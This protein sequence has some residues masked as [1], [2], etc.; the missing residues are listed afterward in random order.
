FNSCNELKK[1]FHEAAVNRDS[2][3]WWHLKK[4]IENTS[5]VNSTAQVWG[6]I[7]NL[8]GKTMKDACI[9]NFKEA[10]SLM[11]EANKINIVGLRSSEVAAKYVEYLLKE[12]SRKINQM[13]KDVE[14]IY[15][16]LLQMTT[17]EV[18]IIFIHAPFTVQTIEA[19]K[20]CYEA[21]IKVILIT[22]LMSCPIT[23]YAD[24]VVKVQASETQYTIVP[25]I[26]LIE[27]MVIE[28]GRNTPENSAEHLD[29][30]G[31]MLKDKKI[32]TTEK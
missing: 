5:S 3:T 18:L 12:R 19:A 16:R 21:G 4:S 23:P 28:Y 9:N 17:N 7:I 1:T 24:V 26:S 32:T 13:N 6:E 11:I 31:Q 15:D 10:V 30:L 20:Y 29:V 27:A 25:T 8:L 14:F 2:K 22:N